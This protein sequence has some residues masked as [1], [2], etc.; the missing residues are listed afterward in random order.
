MHRE[1]LLGDV[2]NRIQ[3]GQPVLLTGPHGIGKTWVLRRLAEEIPGAIYIPHISSKKAVLL[4]I[5]QRLWEDGHLEE[6]AYFADWEDV[7]KRLRHK[8]IPELTALVEE[9]LAEYVVLVDNLQLAS[10]KAMLDVVLPLLSARICAAGRNETKPEQRRLAFIADRFY[11]VELPPLEPNEARAMLWSLLDRDTIRHWQVVETK[12]L[13][14]ARG[15][16]GIIADLATRLRGGAANLDDIRRLS[17]SAAPVPRVNLLWPVGILVIAGLFAGRYLARGMDDPTL[18]I[19]A[20]LA[21]ASTYLLR[22]ILYR[23]R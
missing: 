6:F 15:R 22:P 21:Y 4:D 2:K 5:A 1:T 18:Y 3:R 7:A 9:H 20:A 19:L 12:I 16:P 14:E 13:G 8:T 23:A 10:E 11:Q 17:H